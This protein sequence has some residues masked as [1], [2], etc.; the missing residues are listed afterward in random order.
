MSIMPLTSLNLLFVQPHVF[1]SRWSWQLDL[2]D[3]RPRHRHPERAS[4]ERL[5]LRLGVR[6]PWPRTTKPGRSKDSEVIATC[7]HW[8]TD[9]IYFNIRYIYIYTDGKLDELVLHQR[10]HA[11]S[12]NNVVHTSQQVLRLHHDESLMPGALKILKWDAQAH[13]DIRH[14]KTWKPVYHVYNAKEI[15]YHLFARTFPFTF[16]GIERSNLAASC[17]VTRKN[18][19][20]IYIRYIYIRLYVCWP[21]V[22]I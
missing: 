17:S 16:I 12:R 9:L 2:E 15:I 22:G 4:R 7:I 6:R 8:Y 10:E 21:I 5:H 14:H 13:I 3:R 18:T 1:P 19:I 20:Y 11:I